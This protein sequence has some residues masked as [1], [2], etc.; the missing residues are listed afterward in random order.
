[1][2]QLIRMILVAGSGLTTVAMILF[3]KQFQL[4]GNSALVA[5]LM[6]LAPD[7]PTGWN[8]PLPSSRMQWAWSWTGSMPK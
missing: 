7:N 2:T 3:A 8:L 1:M 5:T 4:Q 6:T